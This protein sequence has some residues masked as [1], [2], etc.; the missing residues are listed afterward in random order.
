MSAV[1]LN[2]KSPAA[3]LNAFQGAL[4]ERLTAIQSQT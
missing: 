4:P 2:P 3:A 1:V